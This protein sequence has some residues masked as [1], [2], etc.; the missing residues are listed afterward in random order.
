MNDECHYLSRCNKYDVLKYTF[1]KSVSQC[2]ISVSSKVILSCSKN[3]EAGCQ[4]SIWRKHFSHA[5]NQANLLV[6]QRLT[7]FIFKAIDAEYMH[8]SDNDA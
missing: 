4:H 3:V 7:W 2:F 6:H 1:L 8:G 5:V